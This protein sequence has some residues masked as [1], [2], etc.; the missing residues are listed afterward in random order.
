MEI[1]ATGA[2]RILGV[3]A[4]PD[5]EVFVAGGTLA[6]YAAAGS[7][8]MVISSTKGQAGQIRDARIATRRTLG[9]VRAQELHTSSAKLGVKHSVCWD[10]GDGTLQELDLDVLVGDVVRTIRSFRPDV[11][12]AF[13]PD[14]GY[15]HP[16]HVTMSLA[17]TDAVRRAAD[18]AA[19]PEQIDDGLR[20]HQPG[21]YYQSYFPQ[22]RLLLLERLVQW[23]VEHNERFKGSLDFVQALMLLSEESTMLKY[24]GDFMTINWYP[25]GF[26][27]IE[28]GEVATTLYLILS[29]RAQAVEEHADGTLEPRELLEPGMFFGEKGLAYHKLRNAHVIAVESTTCLVFSPGKPSNFAGRG[30]EAH[31]VDGATLSEQLTA[32]AGAA[33]TCID[34]GDFVRQKVEAMAA[35]RSQ[36][37]LDPDML[38]LS[39][40]KELFGREYFIRVYPAPDIASE[41]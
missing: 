1:I 30:E 4:H 21:R 16:D 25:P 6:K 19:F 38:P 41:L 20:P 5:D 27:I 40:M 34:V 29:G 15:G 13:G 17:T 39:I 2:P 31:L 24:A 23:L 37:A 9:E 28:Q 22:S 26:Y 12:L 18:P 36:F 14:G 7:E 3:F 8:I 33:T 11:V 35:H 10:Y 32:D